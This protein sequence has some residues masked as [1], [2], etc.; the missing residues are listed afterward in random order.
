[1]SR[2]TMSS[3]VSVR[4]MVGAPWWGGRDARR[5]GARYSPVGSKY[6]RL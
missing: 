2:F 5:T 3:A 6:P 4:F 1:M